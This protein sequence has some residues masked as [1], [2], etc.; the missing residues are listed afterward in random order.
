MP[1]V[2]SISYSFLKSQGRLVSIGAH[3]AAGALADVTGGFDVLLSRAKSEYGQPVSERQPWPW[4]EKLQNQ[5]RDPTDY[6]GQAVRELSE[7]MWDGVHVTTWEDTSTQ[8]SLTYFPGRMI[9]LRTGRLNTDEP[10][11]MRPTALLAIADRAGQVELE[12][13]WSGP[14]E[15]QRRD[16]LEGLITK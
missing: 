5:S 4:R 11:R 8:I 3:V 13:E 10:D 6:I 1:G 9:N 2:K 14:D 15:R 7:R 12:R 16:T